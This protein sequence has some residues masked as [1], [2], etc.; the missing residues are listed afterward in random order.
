MQL[1]FFGRISHGDSIFGLCRGRLRDV[2]R[3]AARRY[4]ADALSGQAILAKNTQYDSPYP[5]G[6]WQKGQTEHRGVA[7]YDPAKAAN[8]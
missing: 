2:R 3:G 8:G 5:P 1:R 6:L 4:L 7:T